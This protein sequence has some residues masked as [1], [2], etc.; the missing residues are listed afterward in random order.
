[1]G[2]EQNLNYVLAMK[3]TSLFDK[4]DII[5]VYCSK[6]KICGNNLSI[7]LLFANK[8]PPRSLL[9]SKNSHVNRK[10]YKNKNYPPLSL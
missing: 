9:R 7:I 8:R 6:L 2:T 5:G 10:K 1:M 4:Y 3:K